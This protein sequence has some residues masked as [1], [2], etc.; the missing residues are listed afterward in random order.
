MTGR[1]ASAVTAAAA[2]VAFVL[3]VHKGTFVPA[4]T[5]PYGYVSQ[6]D[7]IAG[8]SI[9]IDQ[10]FALTMP[11]PDAEWSF[12]PPGYAIATV[13]GFIVPTYSTGLPLVM[14]AF[15]RVSG[16]R[17]AVFYVVPL[18][19]AIAVWM[20]GRLGARVHSRLAGAISAV[21]LA[22]S[23]SFVCQSVQPV[24]DVPAAAWWTISL[25]LAVRPGSW[26]AI[27]AGLAASMAILT[28][29]NLAPLAAVLGAF[30]V[31]SVVR[32]G[33]DDRRAAFRHLALFVIAAIPGCLAVAALNRY[34]YGSPLRSGYGRLD[35]LYAWK[36][37]LP[38]LNRY[39]RWLVETQSPLVCL[40]PAAPFVANGVQ[41]PDE[42][43]LRAD[44]VWLLLAFSAAVLLSY[45]FWGVF[46]IDNWFYLRF[47][48]PA[49]P[50]LL[51]LSVVVAIEVPRRLAS[52]K[53]VGLLASILLC[54][55][56]ASWEMWI[57]LDRRVL[58]L[59]LAERPYRDVG[60]YAARV[61]PR[62]AIFIAGLHSGTIRYYANRLT[63]NYDRLD[64]KS[65]DTAIAALRARGYHP[66][67]AL[68][69]GEQPTFAKKFGSRSELS[70]LDWPPAAQGSNARIWDP[71]DRRLFL[72]GV[73]IVTGDIGLTRKPSVTWK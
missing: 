47:L 58:D 34:L 69:E 65:L 63:V 25:A 21:L 42:P 19:G 20:T 71:L 32:P 43:A 14:A 40:A 6:A 54:A 36:R 30:F 17:A 50:P 62:E 9:R 66:Y 27:G 64:P 39:P 45:L 10:R 67:I 11:W 61:M 31:W 29:P 7:A 22:A 60:Q 15:E 24:S 23:P 57:T 18:L 8:G 59:Q 41:R 3:G 38:N 26:S 46:E 44:H 53:D 5:D 55:V 49:Y 12:V 51:V 1:I 70:R 16:R 35:D 37:L 73:G 52:R 68:E 4:D 48:L 56:A 33:A 72:S 13:P 28:R 2:V